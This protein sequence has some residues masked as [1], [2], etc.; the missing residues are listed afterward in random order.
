M[1]GAFGEQHDGVVV[2]MTPILARQI[3]SDHLASALL[4]LVL[5]ALFCLLLVF[6]AWGE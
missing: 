4:I 5:F 6:T 1:D 2:A 3:N